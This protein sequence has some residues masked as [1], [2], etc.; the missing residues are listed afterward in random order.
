MDQNL[1]QY[2]NKTVTGYSKELLQPF[3]LCLL[4]QLKYAMLVLKKGQ[5]DNNVYNKAY[6]HKFFCQ[7]STAKGWQ[8]I[9]TNKENKEY[10]KDSKMAIV[11][12]LLPIIGYYF[13]DSSILRFSI[14]VFED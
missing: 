6:L 8:K 4:P 3:L 11:K 7:L 13:I 1:C 10:G 14:V 12:I 5:W 9:T 2:A